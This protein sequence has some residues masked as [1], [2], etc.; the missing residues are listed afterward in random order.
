MK[1]LSFG[2]AALTAIWI[3]STASSFVLDWRENHLLNPLWHG[4]ARFH[5][6][7]LLFTLAGV[8][9]V[10]IWTLWRRSPEP[11]HAL[12]LNALL[13]L[14]YWTPLFYVNSL[15]PGST[16]WAGPPGHEPRWHGTIIYPN[17]VVAAVF[18][19]LI[20]AVLATIP[21]STK[22]GA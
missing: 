16:L 7:L 4:H 13:L 19:G 12:R 17:L 5:G 10:G 8:S 22:R 20:V 1:T 3:A 15:L 21:K 2:R 9:L 18:V 11:A 14:C 6:G